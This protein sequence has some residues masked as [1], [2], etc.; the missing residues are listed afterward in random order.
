MRGSAP[1]ERWPRAS[2]LR[3]A[4][5]SRSAVTIAVAGIRR[6]GAGPRH[7]IVAARRRA[8][9]V[10]RLCSRTAADRVL[11]RRQGL[12]RSSCSFS[13]DS[14]RLSA[15]PTC[16]HESISATAVAAALP[17]GLLAVAILVVNNLRDIPTD[18][19]AGKN[20]LAVRLGEK[21]TRRLFALLSV[22]ALVTVFVTSVRSRESLAAPGPPL[23][24]P[25]R[26]SS[27]GSSINQAAPS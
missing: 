2:S 20:T 10:L 21:R 17:V 8:W 16:K 24:A 15:P 4:C 1:A 11:T 14:W 5:G 18:S 6:A 19:V 26:A 25:A 3:R 23:L 22:A 13:S 7:H 27:A 12:V 9:P